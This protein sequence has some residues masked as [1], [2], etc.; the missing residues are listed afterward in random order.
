MKKIYNNFAE[1]TKEPPETPIE[2]E[3]RAELTL[4]ATTIGMDDEVLEAFLD[5]IGCSKA[6]YERLTKKWARVLAR[7]K[8]EAQDDRTN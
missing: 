6:E 3:R 2:R 7:Y 1:F 8:E 4:L 5:E